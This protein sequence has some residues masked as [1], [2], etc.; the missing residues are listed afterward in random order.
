[1][2]RLVPSHWRPKLCNMQSGVSCLHIECLLSR[3]YFVRCTIKF[4]SIFICRHVCDVVG[5]GLEWRCRVVEAILLVLC[6]SGVYCDCMWIS[7]TPRATMPSMRSTTCDTAWGSSSVST[8]NTPFS[9]HVPWQSGRFGALPFIV[10][11]LHN[12]T[13]Q[14]IALHFRRLRDS[15]LM[16]L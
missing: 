7:S 13:I 2:L 5:N 16:G 1:M 3:L 4:W 11:Q 10:A 14:S 6:R 8:L 15:R 9:T 12:L